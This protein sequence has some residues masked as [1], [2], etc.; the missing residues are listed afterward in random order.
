VEI[1]ALITQEQYEIA[2]R[3]IVELLNLSGVIVRSDEVDRM[4]VTD[5][6]LGEFEQCGI[7]IVTLVDTDK[8]GVKLIVLFPNQVVP[9][10][11]HPAQGKYPGKEE[12]I[13]CA[14]GELYLY[15]PG[16]PTPNLKGH[17][18]QQRLQTY[19]VWH[20]YI[21]HPGDQ[22]TF[23][24]GTA[25]WFQAGPSGVVVWSFS[26]KATDLEDIF[27]DTEVRRQTIVIEIK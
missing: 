5:L 11:I 14:W 3:R 15:G 7:Q 25:H 22:V 23:Q 16:E 18:P 9:E 19:N 2:R 10:H 17:P 24:P 20:E 21:L 12:T 8:I 6:N 4:E 13:R 27:T 1:T 26:T